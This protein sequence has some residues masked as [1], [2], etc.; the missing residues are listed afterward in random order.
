MRDRSAC[1]PSSSSTPPAASSR[2]DATQI[3]I[4]VTVTTNSPA[5]ASAIGWL[6]TGGVQR[7]R[8]P[9]VTRRNSCDRERDRRG[10]DQD[11]LAEPVPRVQRRDHDAADHQLQ[12]AEIA[13]A[14]TSASA[15]PAIGSP[16]PS[17]T[18]AA[19]PPIAP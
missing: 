7:S 12:P 8:A 13:A 14:I 3:C 10:R 15:K 11:R 9:C 1:A 4:G 2:D 5:R 16:T 18:A 19:T 17:A 6:N